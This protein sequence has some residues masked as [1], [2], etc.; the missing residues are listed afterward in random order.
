MQAEQLSYMTPT[1]A[2]C[3]QGN[4]IQ[5]QN[6]FEVNSDHT[7]MVGVLRMLD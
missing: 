5:R 6:P 3:G 4:P 1:L 7:T 2:L